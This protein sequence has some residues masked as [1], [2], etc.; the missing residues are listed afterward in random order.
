MWAALF[1]LI[2]VCSTMVFSEPQPVEPVASVEP[3]GSRIA[4]QDNQA[5]IRPLLAACAGEPTPISIVVVSPASAND[6]TSGGDVK[7]D[8]AQPSPTECMEMVIPDPVLIAIP[9]PL[10]ASVA[11]AFAPAVTPAALPASAEATKADQRPKATG[12]KGSPSVMAPDGENG[13]HMHAVPVQ[14]NSA[15]PTIAPALQRP[16]QDPPLPVNQAGVAPVA[17]VPGLLPSMSVESNSVSGTGFQTIITE[18]IA[19]AAIRPLSDASALVADRAMDVARGSLWLDQ[20]A[21][22]IAAMQDNDRDLVFRLIPAQLGQLDV[23]IANRDDG[24]Q[25]SFNTQTDEA[26]HIIGGA[27]PRLVEE[28]KAQGVRVAGSEVNTGS[29]HQSFGH[30][31]SAQQNGQSARTAAI[32]ELERPSLV[33]PEQTTANDPQNGRFA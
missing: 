8:E 10:P 22:D 7:R 32:A 13:A 3:V 27:Q 24:I 11:S 14:T 4:A 31:S 28:L 2:A 17:D 30:Q 21:G 15:R 12:P 1:G 33:S 18:R 5:T 29:G 26:A 6:E 25:L 16:T 20:L 19:E 9:V 23:K